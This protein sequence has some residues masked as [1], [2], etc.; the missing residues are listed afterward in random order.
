[1]TDTERLA[2][3]RER[4]QAA[5]PGPWIEEDGFILTADGKNTVADFVP[6]SANS[7]FMAAARDDVPF[8]LAEV[9]RLTRLLEGLTPGGSEFHGATDRCA[10]FARDRMGGAARQ[11]LLRKAAEAEVE[12][13]T[14]ERDRLREALVRL[15][16]DYSYNLTSYNIPGKPDALVCAC[17]ACHQWEDIT[18]TLTHAADCRF[19]VLN[20]EAADAK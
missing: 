12:R 2:E 10:E 19:A 18:G 20:K 13:L 9:E 11:V 3:I 8:L 5:T 16:R 6:Y 14:A 15:E 7:V 4:E 1:M 17:R